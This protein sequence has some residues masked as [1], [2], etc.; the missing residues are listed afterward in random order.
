M[1]LP[2]SSAFDWPAILNQLVTPPPVDRP[3]MSH[4]L[5][6]AA[7]E[8]NYDTIA[9]HVETEI[10][11]VSELHDAHIARDGELENAETDEHLESPVTPRPPNR[12]ELPY[13]P[14]GYVMDGELARDFLA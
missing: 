4:E 5:D 10:V 14:K 1:E 7:T 12:Y 9:T 3:D 6:D 11:P 13:V 2:S 8:I